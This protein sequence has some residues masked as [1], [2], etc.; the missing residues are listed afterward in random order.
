MSAK[1][2]T[3]G[4]LF[5][6]FFTAGI[7]AV[8]LS[9]MALE[10]GTFYRDNIVLGRLEESNKRLKALDEQY[11]YQLEQIKKNPAVLGRLKVLNLGQEPQDPQ[12]AYPPA[13]NAELIQAARDILSQREVRSKEQPPLVPGWLIRACQPRARIALFLAGTAL[14]IIAMTCFNTREEP[15]GD[16]DTETALNE[17]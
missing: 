5:L 3:N 17:G 9:I 4:L 10:I 16:H 15:A 14:I 1:A 11:A 8:S 7:G 12:T 13:S 2:F 6:V